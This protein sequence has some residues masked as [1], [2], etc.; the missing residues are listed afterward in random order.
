MDKTSP[1][2]FGRTEL[3]CL[4]FLCLQPQSA[5]LKLRLLLLDSPLLAPLALM[6]RRFF[7]GSVA[8]CID[9]I[10]MTFIPNDIYCANN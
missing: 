6:R 10:Q 3:A 5:W 1:R 2:T 8:C 9:S 4:Y 7:P